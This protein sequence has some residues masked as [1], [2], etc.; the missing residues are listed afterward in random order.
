MTRPRALLVLCHAAVGAAMVILALAVLGASGPVAAHGK[1]PKGIDLAP[2]GQLVTQAGTR[3]DMARLR[4]RPAA[5]FFGYTHCPDICPTTMLEMSRHLDQLGRDGE[6][7]EVLFVTIDPERDSAAHL[8]DYV[9]SFHPR[10]VA[11]TGPP[12]E[13]AAVAHAFGANYE[14]VEP[15]DGGGNYTMDHTAKVY[16]LDRYGLVASHLEPRQTE[17][18]QLLLLR[19]LLAQ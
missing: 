18:E 8:K 5:V 7:L 12:L 3:F 17:K 2:L 9:G 15:K 19:K 11:L 1:R 6:R 16:L 10:I 14:K 13:V 4:G